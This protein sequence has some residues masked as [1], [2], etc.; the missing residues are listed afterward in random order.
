MC[1]IIGS[2]GKSID[3]KRFEESRDVMMHR[4]PDD[5]G[6][7]Y[8]KK[9]NVAFGHRRLSIIDLSE[10][11]N[12]PFYS[13]DKRF[14]L[15][16]NGE[17]YNYI[18]LKKELEGDYNFK[19]KTDTEVLLAAY[20]KWGIECLDRLNGMFSFAIW[21]SKDKKLVAYHK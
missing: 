17:I 3:K 12:Q 20:I 7:Y 2:I 9:S 6:V 1:A 4:G 21:D 8:D 14:V 5:S 10:D 13:D 19:T 15:V 11:G 18:E 16:F